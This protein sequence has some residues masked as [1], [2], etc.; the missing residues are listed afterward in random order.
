[1]IPTKYDS[2]VLF[3]YDTRVVLLIQFGRSF[4]SARHAVMTG[5]VTDGS[6][7]RFV[8][9]AKSERQKKRKRKRKSIQVAS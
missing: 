8:G 2:A 9:E 7:G 3:F 5:L 1:M 4:R 6:V